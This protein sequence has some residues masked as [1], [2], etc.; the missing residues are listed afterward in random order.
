MK[1]VS[2]RSRAFAPMRASAGLVHGEQAPQ[3]GGEIGAIVGLG[4]EAGDAVLD[5]FRQAADPAGDDGRARACAS[6][7][8]LGAFS[9][10]TEGSATA[11]AAST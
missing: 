4:E 10:Q 9:Y 11:L 1:V 2:A 8:L 5:Q 3:R 6:R 7:T